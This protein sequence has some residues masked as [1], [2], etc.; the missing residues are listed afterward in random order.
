MITAGIHGLILL[1]F[2]LTSVP[3][4]QPWSARQHPNHPGDGRLLSGWESRRPK[5]NQLIP[6]VNNDCGNIALAP[7]CERRHGCQRK[8][9]NT[10][11]S[12][13]EHW[14]TLRKTFKWDTGFV[15][16]QV[17]CLVQKARGKTTWNIQKKNPLMNG[18]LGAATISYPFHGAILPC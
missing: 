9:L 15:V 11:R 13:E 5:G 16:L 10:F 1:F 4:L 6:C 2:I 3:A 18:P 7:C 12:I 14:Q 17:Y 8:Q